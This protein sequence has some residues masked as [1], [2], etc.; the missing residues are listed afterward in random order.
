MPCRRAIG[1]VLL[2]MGCGVCPWAAGGPA[3]AEVVRHDLIMP[4][5]AS[6]TDEWVKTG[7]EPGPV[8]VVIGGLHGDEV[9]GYKA[10]DKL[11]EWTITRGKL[12]LIPEAHKQAIR[13]HVRAY[14]GDMNA[15]F[16]GDPDGTDMERLAHAIWEKIKEAQPGL[17][18]TLHESRGF[19]ARD[20]HRYGQTLTHDFD[21]I[22]P[23]VRRAIARVNPSI[24]PSLHQF[25]IFVKPIPTC[26]TYNAWK[27]LRI[28]ATSIETA[29]PLPLD[30]RIRYQLMMLM[31]LFDEVGLGYEQS[32]VPRLPSAARPA[33][34]DLS[35]Y[36]SEVT[37]EQTSDV[38]P[39]EQSGEAKGPP[40]S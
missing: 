26:P 18:I 30:Q 15:M 39:G 3:P 35:T 11:R 19:R 24:S 23:L 7:P 4:G 6:E 22:N 37:H 5:T 13:R 31:G 25:R 2:A 34:T 27:W 10:A 21:V 14:P 38:K 36:V 9:A 40:P 12:V 29:R 17:L 8:I 20:P 16:P 1:C 33:G 28:P 32:D